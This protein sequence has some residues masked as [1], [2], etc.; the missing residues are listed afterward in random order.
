AL[1]NEVIKNL[2]LLGIQRVIIVDRDRV[3]RSNL[4]RSILYCT[5][6]IE[7]E[8]A[9]GT[10]KA[11]FA[12]RR[13]REINPDVDVEAHV[14][15]VGDLGGGIIRRAD[16]VFSCLD[17]EMARLELSAW[18]SRL[19]RRLIDGGLGLMNY[20]SGMV[21]IYPGAGGPCYACRK[22]TDRRRQLLQELY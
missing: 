19:D 21:S 3:E 7:Q 12:A 8:I 6:D 9:R 20:S 10:P 16:V 22:G 15:E 13:A 4:T 18:C 1:G 17:N 2:A 11:S 5:T 14:G